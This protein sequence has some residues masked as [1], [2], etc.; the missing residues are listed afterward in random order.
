[1][2][3]SIAL[4]AREPVADVHHSV[5]SITQ[6]AKLLN[7]CDELNHAV[8]VGY[9]ADHDL[10]R[11][12]WIDPF[13]LKIALDKLLTI[14]VGLSADAETLDQHLELAARGNNSRK[15][16]DQATRT[17]KIIS[18]RLDRELRALREALAGTAK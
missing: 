16:R 13:D 10:L 15:L 5:A 14:M 2:N 11:V 9:V 7:G 4:A 18:N 8:A 12:A 6:T 1:M 17:A 3:K